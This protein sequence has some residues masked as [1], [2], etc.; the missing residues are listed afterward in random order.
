MFQRTWP[1]R[2]DSVRDIMQTVEQLMGRYGLE[3]RRVLHMGLVVEELAANI[4]NHAY[5]DMPQPP[6]PAEIR[7]TAEHHQGLIRLIF[8]DAGCPFDPS[9]VPEPDLT[10]SIDDR[11]VGGLGIYFMRNLVDRVHYQR[12]GDTNRWTFEIQTE[13]DAAA[14]TDSPH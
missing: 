2:I 13:P 3:Q 7:L 6:D 1:A 11:H 8:H 14:S 10:A 4:V 12:E 5:G 9:T